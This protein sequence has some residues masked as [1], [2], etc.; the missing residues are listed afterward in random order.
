MTLVL[1]VKDDP[2]LFYENE[3]K[4]GFVLLSLWFEGVKKF[5][6]TKNSD[7]VTYFNFT[8]DYTGLFPSGNNGIHLVKTQIPYIKSDFSSNYNETSKSLSPTNNTEGESIEN[9][10]YKLMALSR[11]EDR[12][13][14]SKIEI[15]TTYI[16]NDKQVRFIY[17]RKNGELNYYTGYLG[18]IYLDNLPSED[19]NQQVSLSENSTEHVFLIGSIWY[20]VLKTSPTPNIVYRNLPDPLIGE[21]ETHGPSETFPY[22]EGENAYELLVKS[23]C[24]NGIKFAA[25]L[26]ILQSDGT[27]DT[28]VNRSFV[29]PLNFSI[30]SVQTVQKNA[31]T[32]FYLKISYTGSD[33]APIFKIT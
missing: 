12:E 28:N 11:D 1:T 24:L 4:K 27:Y 25:F 23:N 22:Q 26:S 29:V 18:N 10:I 13:I 3:S 32:Y 14:P 8:I 21:I 20:I 16:F 19:L 9:G 2:C 31:K 30:N 33:T 7:T 5:K 15:N 6:I 17:Y